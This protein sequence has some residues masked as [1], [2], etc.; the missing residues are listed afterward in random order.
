MRGIIIYLPDDGRSISRNVAHLNLLVHDMT[1][2]LYY[3]SFISFEIFLIFPN[4]VISQIL[5]RSVSREA[6]PIYHFITNN[7]DSCHLWWKENKL[8][9]QKSRRIMNMIAAFCKNSFVF[10][11]SY[12]AQDHSQYM[13]LIFIIMFNTIVSIRT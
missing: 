3:N 4:F 9:H 8:N 5:L 2:L 13:Y 1:N 11:S 12:N 10:W 6:T 7:Y